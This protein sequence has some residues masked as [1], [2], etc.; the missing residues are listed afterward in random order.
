MWELAWANVREHKMRFVAAAVAIVAGVSFLTAGS[1]LTASISRSLGGEVDDQ[2]RAVSAAVQPPEAQGQGLA[3]VQIPQSLLDDVRRVP[4]VR[5]AV[6]EVLSVVSILEDGKRAVPGTFDSGQSFLRTWISE[7]DLNPLQITEGR[8]PRAEGEVTV[9]RGT[10]ADRHLRVGS[11]ISLSSS[12][13]A[14]EATVVGITRFGTSDAP[15]AGGTLTASLPW[16]FSLGGDGSA[17]FARILVVGDDDGVTPGELVGRIEKVVPGSLQVVT[18]DTFREEQKG[19]TAAIS[20]VLGPVLQGFAYLSLFVAGFVIFNTFAVVVAQRARELALVRAV[21]ATPKQVRRSLKVEGLVV[22]LVGSLLGVAFGA[23]LTLALIAVLRALDLDLPS[24]GVV[25]TPGIVIQGLLSGVIVTVASVAIPARRA[26]KTPP[27]EAMRSS[28]TEVS[29]VP[30]SRVLT[31][32][33][34]VVLG[35]FGLVIGSPWYVLGLGALLFLVGVFVAGPAIVTVTAGA[36]AP[37]TRWFG[38]P[39]RLARENLRRSPRRTATT[40]N[41]L[42]IGLFLVTLVSVGGAS[43]RDWTVGEVDQLSSAD[44]VV[45]TITGAMPEGLLDR[46]DSIGGIERSARM[47][48]VPVIESGNPTTLTA[49]DPA[50]LAAVGLRPSSGRWSDGEGVVTAFVNQQPAQVGQD[51]RVTLPDGRA[52]T[53]GVSGVLPFSFDALMIGNLVTPATLEQLVPGTPETGTLLSVERGSYDRVKD[54][55]DALTA[56]YSSVFVIEGNILGRAIASL[57]DFLINAVNALLGM[58][59]V[60]ALVGIVNTLSLSIFERRRELGLL[61]AV[62]MTP[63]EVRAMVLL[64]ALFIAVVGTVVGMATGAVMAWLLLRAADV[65]GGV[66]IEPG[67]LAVV[68]LIGLGSGLVASIFPLR[69]VTR[70]DVVASIG[71]A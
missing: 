1:M 29:G 54:R 36:L 34:M 44:F 13:G 35:L 19:D 69:R 31:A 66:T 26:A 16:A 68:A 67:R 71:G 14:V 30:R 2:Y 42:V 20:E 4:G 6:G 23:A 10:A 48:S 62:G 52:V 22:G 56:G 24:A 28:A 11:K 63:G 7:A 59:V 38:V 32:A 43:L 50:A 39:G 70:L 58:S 5:A 64:E 18:G 3:R 60:V 55:L 33:A 40:A 45:T 47:R 46:I 15:D 12:T 41:A 25:V 57:F 17:S 61:R 8:P 9:D 37:L 65:S 21:A 49:A 51:V 27:V 53:L